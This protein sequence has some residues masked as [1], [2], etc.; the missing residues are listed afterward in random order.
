MK[1][2]SGALFPP[3][4]FTL[5]LD[6]LLLTQVSSLPTALA[7]SLLAGRSNVAAL[8]GPENLGEVVS[9]ETDGDINSMG[10]M[11]IRKWA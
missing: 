3:R 2:R 8:L 5:S 6:S 1:L 7:L 9:P 4:S 10:V 11:G